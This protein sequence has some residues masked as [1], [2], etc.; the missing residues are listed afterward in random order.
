MQLMT[1]QGKVIKGFNLEE[2]GESKEEHK[3]IILKF[4][5]K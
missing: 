4:M 1:F 3:K 2:R 5:Q